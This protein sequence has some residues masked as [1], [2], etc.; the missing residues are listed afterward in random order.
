M[1][2]AE[3]SDALTKLNEI[4]L[5]VHGPEDYLDRV[6][7]VLAEE[8]HFSAIPGGGAASAPTSGVLLGDANLDMRVRL[9]QAG[10]SQDDLA[11]HLGKSQAFI[12][13]LLS[14]K[15]HWPEGLREQA[16]AFIAANTSAVP[17]GRTSGKR[18]EGG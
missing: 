1:G 3:V 10:L 11:G 16:E 2:I 13:Q 5:R 4:H 8:G 12:S 17:D 7:G 14:G 15:K 18:C 6:R 9:Q